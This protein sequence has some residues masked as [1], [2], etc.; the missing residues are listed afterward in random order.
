M[1]GR[2]FITRYPLNDETSSY[3][4]AVRVDGFQS[5]G[6]YIVTQQPLPNT[7]GDFWRLIDENKVS[8]IISLNKVNSEDKTSCIF[9]PTANSTTMNP[10][11]FITLTY[12]NSIISDYFSL[13]KLNLQNKKTLN[14]IFI[15]S[16]K[17][18][19]KHTICPTDLHKF[20]SFWQEA[21]AISRQSQPTVITC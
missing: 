12:V 7:L 10:V 2:V 5:P 14:Q 18:W 19:I 21:D 13:I 16:P 8:V 1:Q 20:I 17:K 3:I 11:D 4:N 15:I 9:W 6:R